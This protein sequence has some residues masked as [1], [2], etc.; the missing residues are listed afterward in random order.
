MIPFYNEETKEWEGTATYMAETEKEAK[1][2]ELLPLGVKGN[3]YYC[4]D[5]NK[6]VVVTI[7]K[8]GK[9]FSTG[10]NIVDFILSLS[11]ELTS[12]VGEQSAGKKYMYTRATIMSKQVPIAL[13]LCYFEGIDGF[14]RRADIKHYFSDTRPRLAADENC[15]QFEDGYL[16]YTNKP[17][18]TSLLMNGFVDIPTKNYSYGELNDKFVYQGI[19]ETM[20]K[21]VSLGITSAI[22]FSFIF[23][24]FSKVK[25]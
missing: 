11:G 17:T 25:D 5:L 10:K 14:L 6:D 12:R 24:L 21:N 20:L 18:A 2:G 7:D 13:L 8:N 1:K 16:V 9:T 19:F 22:I 15:I 3:I 23:S 4:I